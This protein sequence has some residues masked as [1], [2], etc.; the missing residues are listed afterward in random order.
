ML[1]QSWYVGTALHRIPL[2]LFNFYLFSARFTA[3]ETSAPDADDPTFFITAPITL[4]MSFMVVAFSSATTEAAIVSN[5]STDNCGGRYLH[6]FWSFDTL[7]RFRT[8]HYSLWGS[9]LQKHEN[10]LF[11]SMKTDSLG[12]WKRTLQKHENGLFRSMKTDSSGVWKRDE[13][14]TQ[15]QI[16]DIKL[17]STSFKRLW[18]RNISTS[19]KRLWPSTKVGHNKSSRRFDG[20]STV[21]ALSQPY[22][23]KNH[24]DNHEDR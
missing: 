3:A 4:P 13:R 16:R 17:D 6:A 18:P 24:T 14:K 7:V 20:G 5:S 19:F 15:P 21:H 10:G 12:A 2:F 23:F 11:R 9:T 1:A 22:D 8:H